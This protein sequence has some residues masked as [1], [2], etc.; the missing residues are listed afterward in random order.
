MRE[1]LKKLLEKQQYRI[2]GRHSA[3]KV[4]EYVKK[5]LTGKDVCYKNTFYGIQSHRCVQMTPTLNYCPNEC[6]FC[7]RAM[8]EEFNEGTTIKKEDSPEKIVNGCI[9]EQLQMIVGFKG[10]KNLDWE[11]YEESQ[12]PLHFAIS[13][14]G[15]PAIYPRLK[16]MVEII[17]KKGM[18]SFVVSNGMYPEKL[19][20]IRPTQLYVSV[21]A[22]D[23]ELY[24]K[25]SRTKQDD[26]WKKLM[27]SMDVLNELRKGGVRTCLRITAIKN[28]NMIKPESYAG[29]IR[30]AN[31]TFVEVKS[32][33]W[34]GF[35][36][37]RLRDENMPLHKETKAF[38]EEI[39]KHCN[40]KVIDE[41]MESRV[42]LMMKEE[43]IKN[44]FLS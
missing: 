38:A 44:R 42:V 29:I 5:S 22:P 9:N 2:V 17:R 41:K 43:D 16:E 30:R 27:Q 39:A 4:C 15:E 24:N 36:R 31:P 23:E 33:M 28:M 8:D 1:E 7:W 35:S 14:S 20:E 11:R 19:R 13:L 3:S 18:T 6:V 32:Y 25:I 21:F 12:N 26:A 40:Y 37:L 10:N 34:V